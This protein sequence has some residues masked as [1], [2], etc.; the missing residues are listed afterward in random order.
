M[1]VDIDKVRKPTRGLM[2]LTIHNDGDFGLDNYAL[3]KVMDDILLVEYIDTN[4]TG[5]YINRNGLAIP[6]NTLTKAWRKAKVI[7]KGPGVQYTDIGDIV[8][9]PNNLGIAVSNIE[10]KGAG[11]VK[12]GIFINEQRMFGICEQNEDNETD[13]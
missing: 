3:S 6:V 13:A 12:Q 5:E 9:F 10:V 11:K 4:P 8:I 1:P 2:D 7:L